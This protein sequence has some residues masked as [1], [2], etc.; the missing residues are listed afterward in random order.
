MHSIEAVYEGGVFR[1]LGEVQC[2]ENQ[3]V[4]LT[5]ELAQRAPCDRWLTA[6]Q[7]F[8]RQLIANHGVLPD[9]TPDISA[10]RRRHE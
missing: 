10:D 9:S 6:V 8:Q 5:I 1:P 4:Y 7:D 2:R 3:R